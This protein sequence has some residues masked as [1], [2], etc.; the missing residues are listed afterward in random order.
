MRIKCVPLTKKR[1]FSRFFFQFFLCPKPKKNQG[2]WKSQKKP[3]TH[4]KAE[5]RTEKNPEGAPSAQHVVTV[6]SAASGA[7][8]PTKSDPCGALEGVLAD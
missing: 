7:L 2:E 5:N 8:Q 6:E 4:L 1:V 3:K